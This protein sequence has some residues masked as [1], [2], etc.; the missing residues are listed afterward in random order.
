[1][2]VALAA[3]GNGVAET[4]RDG[5]NRARDVAL[6]F[7]L[8]LERPKCSQRRG[9]HQRARPRPKI[10]RGEFGAGDLLE[11]L[12][13]VGRVDQLPLTGFVDVLKELVAGQ[14]AACLDDLR[15]PPVLE[16][17]G[18]PDTALAA[19]LEAQR[20]SV[21]LRVLVAHRRQTERMIVAGVL[22]VADPDQRL[23]EQLHDRR[24]HL[25]PRQ[26]RLL[27]IGAR[28]ASNAWKHPRERHEAFVLGFVT[29][30]TPARMVAVLFASARVAARRL[31]VAAGVGT[32]PHVRP[33]RRDDDRSDS[34]EFG[35]TGNRAPVGS[36]VAKSVPAP[37]P[38]D[39]WCAVVVDVAKVDVEFRHPHVLQQ[40]PGLEKA[41]G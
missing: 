11:I 28:A 30:L 41:A 33:R 15:E 4:L 34:L 29:R 6:R 23:L 7:G 13:D 36:D 25:L 17:D 2:D 1:M 9:G 8:R 22:L 35:A 14:I 37:E 39:A 16:I 27:Q 18:V 32:D 3:H 26:P 20:R 5:L 19:E 10:F 21:D 12:V 38:A 31:N 24:E 40:N